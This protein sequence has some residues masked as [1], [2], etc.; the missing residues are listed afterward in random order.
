MTHDQIREMVRRVNPVPDSSTLIVEAPV[1]TTPLERRTAM[2]TDNREVT[3]DLGPGRGRGP[4][5]GIAAAAV[6]LIAGLVF[7]LT[8]DNTPVAEPA[9]NA[10]ATSAVEFD[11]ALPPGAY[12]VDT[13]GD[14]ASSLR[15][16]FVIEGSGWTST[17]AGAR[18]ISRGVCLA[19]GRR[20][21]AGVVAGV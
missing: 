9:P 14:E 12:F 7:F 20:G 11:D 19:S 16:T 6:I 5:V 1:L 10:T 2:Q 15:G 21:R 3:D 4:L 18:K 13:D 8:R 17:G